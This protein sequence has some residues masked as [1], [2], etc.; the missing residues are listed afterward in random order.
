MIPNTLDKLSQSLLSEIEKDLKLVVA[1]TNRPESQELHSMLAYHMGWIDEAGSPSS[2]GKRIRPLLVLLTAGAAGGDWQSAIP[3]AS[4]VELLHNFSLIHDDIEDQSPLRRGRPTVW[5]RWGIPQAINC[6]DT[7]F[8]LANLA[9][10]NLLETRDMPTTLR[11]AQALQETCLEL[12]RGQYLDLAYESRSD[13]SLED[14]WTMIGGKTASLLGTC[15]LSGALVAGCDLPT[16][17]AYHEFGLSLGLAFQVQDDLLGIWGD[18]QLTGKS[19]ESD[20]VSGKKSLPVLFGLE[21][22]GEFARRW[23]Q[24]GITAK[25]V[26]QVASQLEREG[27]K[28]YTQERATFYTEKA[29]AGLDEAK[30]RGEFG[31][32]LTELADY[33]LKRNL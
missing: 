33:L 15:T 31:Q 2:G 28:D 20:L 8:T 25:E 21:Q 17:Y 19:A 22:N 12:T 4:A 27:A 10:F 14:Y 11:V 32:A 7:M 5:V 29:L 18:A 1:K 16:Q 3:A 6:G 26:P 30:P 23:A 9:A 24:G 13:L